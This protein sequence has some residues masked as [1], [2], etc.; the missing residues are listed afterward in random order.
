M[1]PVTSQESKMSMIGLLLAG[2][3]FSDQQWK[4]P[5]NPEILVILPDIKS[6]NSGIPD[7]QLGTGFTYSHI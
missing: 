5:E 6:L 3:T 2:N 1:I 7:S 4:I